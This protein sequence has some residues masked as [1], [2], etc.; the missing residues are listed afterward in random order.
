MAYGKIPGTANFKRPAKGQRVAN[1]CT[2][3]GEDFASPGTFDEH[4]IGEHE[5]KFSEGLLFDPPKY[6]GRRCLDTGEMTAMGWS[7]DRHGRWRQEAGE[8]DHDLLVE[9]VDLGAV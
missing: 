3:C 8:F 4:R 7:H 1:F 6:D 9:R 2:A 5:Y